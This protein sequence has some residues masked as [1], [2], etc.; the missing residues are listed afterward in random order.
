MVD[1]FTLIVAS[2]RVFIKYYRFHRFH[3]DD[4]LLIASM[5][6]YIAT[7]SCAFAAVAPAQLAVETYGNID[8]LPEEAIAKIEHYTMLLFSFNVLSAVTLFSVKASFLM[9][10]RLLLNNTG[11]LKVYWWAVFVVTVAF[12]LAASLATFIVC[13]AVGRKIVSK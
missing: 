12:G 1:A 13:P 7:I 4:Y 3:A 9:F 11:K 5:I 8:T 6:F 2:A 10:F